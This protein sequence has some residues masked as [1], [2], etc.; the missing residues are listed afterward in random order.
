MAAL[1][2]AASSWSDLYGAAWSGLMAGDGSSPTGEPPPVTV[3]GSVGQLPSRLRVEDVA[4]ACVAI[5]LGAAA[6][7]V[8][9]DE[10]RPGLAVDRRDVAAA[11]T[12]ERHFRSGSGG[13]MG[14]AT[15][16]R[17]WRCTDGWVRTH[18]NYPWHETA[19][20]QAL[21]TDGDA[22]K[23]AS[24]IGSMEG[25]VVEAAVFDAGGVAAA[26]RSEKDWCD[27]PQGRAIASE[28]LVGHEVIGGAPPRAGHAGAFPLSGV[29]VLDL[30]RVIAGPVCTRYLG[31]LGADVLRVDPPHRPD[32]ARGAFAD[33]LMA[34]R[35]AVL[36]LSDRHGASVLRGL[37]AGADVVVCGYRPGSLDRF[38]LDADTL[39]SRFP[40]LVL[41]Y[42]AAWGHS[43]PWSGRRGFDS[44]VQAPTGIALSESHDGTTPGAL[45]C[46]LLDHGTGYLAAAA[47]MDGLRRQRTVGG[48]HVRRL[49][50]ARTAL[51][52]TSAGGA[53]D[54]PR[55]TEPERRPG[56]SQFGAGEHALSVVDPPGSL[57][58]TRIRWPGPPT[59]YGADAA[60]WA[61][62]EH[63]PSV[64]P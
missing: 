18:A 50:L 51:W 46:Q 15:L 23:V 24:V 52:L 17:F 6:A 13:A 20:R 9:A 44:V 33:T 58:G 37:A 14:F 28:P 64:V 30:T 59:R 40:G 53:G 16:S 36:D 8:R 41:V 31:A 35:S 29:R 19:L 45:P 47:A 43:G 38:G 7:V 21:G 27:H 49:S 32:L 22:E 60:T 1:S 57:G 61:P 2:N 55:P 12:S 25:E 39:A 62:L 34:K 11:V 54:G 26:V 3:E 48:T 63:P 56:A 5:A 42:L 10:A 4:T